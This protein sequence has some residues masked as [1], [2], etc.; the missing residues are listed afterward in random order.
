M[1]TDQYNLLKIFD[2]LDGR[3]IAAVPFRP[4][5]K[6]VVGYKLMVNFAHADVRYLI[7]PFQKSLRVCKGYLISAQGA[8]SR[9]SAYKFFEFFIV[10]F[11]DLNKHFSVI[12]FS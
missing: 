2:V 5:P 8:F 1:E 3:V 11:K 10:I 7:P 9:L 6:V 4:Q 12:F